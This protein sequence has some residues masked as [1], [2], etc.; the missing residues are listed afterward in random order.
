MHI[1][2]DKKIEIIKSELDKELMD[3]LTPICDDDEFIKGVFVFCET[4]KERQKLINKI[5]SGLKN[6]DE[7][8]LYIRDLRRGI[9]V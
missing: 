6:T 5:K 2:E 7:I 1:S 9:T 8:L 3:L 4:N